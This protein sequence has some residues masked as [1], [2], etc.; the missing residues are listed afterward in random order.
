M[1]DPELVQEIISQIFEATSRIERR[2]S[3]IDL[4]EDFLASEEGIDKLD[5]ICMML[6]AIGES[7]KNL[8]KVT[9]GKLLSSILKSTGR[10]PKASEILLVTITLIS[11]LT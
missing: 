11:T 4:P 8:D 3:S 7:L 6:I 5:G 1:S 10:V 2:F 9:S